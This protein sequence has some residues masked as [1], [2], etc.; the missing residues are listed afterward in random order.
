[1][2]D[3]PNALNTSKE[4]STLQER[5]HVFSSA[6]FEAIFLSEK[7]ICIDQ[8]DTAEQMFGWSRE[9]ATGRQ[10]T[11][12]IVP[13]DRELVLDSML[14]GIEDPY[15]VTALRKDGTIFPCEI[16]ARMMEYQGRQVRVT[17]LRDVTRIRLVERRNKALINAIPDLMF[18]V[19]HHGILQ[20]YSKPSGVSLYRNPDEFLGRSFS[21]IIPE[22]IAVQAQQVAAQT[23]VD[24]SVQSFEYE[25]EINKELHTFEARACQYADSQVIFIVRDVTE[26]RRMEASES[27][28][29]R[30][31][32]AGRIAGQIAHD[33]NNLLAPLTGYPELIREELDPKHPVVELVGEMEV[34]AR[35]IADINQKLLCL[36]RRGHYNMEPVDI[37]Q[38]IENVMKE[39]HDLPDT[40]LLN[41]QL[42]TD[43]LPVLGGSAQ[44]SRV[45][46][47][48]VH[49][50]VD[51]VDQR[52]S[53]SISTKNIY[54][55][56]NTT[57]YA[58]IDR[59]EYVLISIRDDGIGIPLENRDKVFDPFFTTKCTDRQRGSGLGLSVVNGVIE[60][61]NGFV[62]L[63]SAI[64]LGS[65]FTVY[66]PITRQTI[67]TSENSIA[68]GNGETILVI[69]DDPI[70]RTV[71]VRLLEHAGYLASAAESGE[72][73]LEILRNQSYDLLVLDMVMPGGIDGGITY[74]RALEINPDQKGIIVSGYAD[75]AAVRKAQQ[76][77][78]TE[79]LKKPV[80]LESLGRAVSRSLPS[81]TQ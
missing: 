71:A 40:V 42:A 81:P 62:N 49:N 3:N 34:S 70:Q 5:F 58:H 61:H 72:Q 80:S 52:G 27:R 77:G 38:V 1:M 20:D 63:E 64:G 43:L 46:A 24:D 69:D 75:T 13:D 76:L 14:S 66:L 44:I 41:K 45:V 21:E 39:F 15:D 53:V 10:G 74:A 11:D 22:H 67:P 56:A 6:S 12:W 60:D 9:E 35:Q 57:E 65:E 55:S 4:L 18:V 47:N 31:E 68:K 48:L 29:K 23:I 25:L 79:Y 17:A 30:L 73:A 32:T 28:A 51:A 26:L 50:A 78:V 2:S 37:N 19:D 16:Q 8:N 33:L 54:L 7:G 36:G 59:G